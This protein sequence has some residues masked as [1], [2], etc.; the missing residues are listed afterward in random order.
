MIHR[1]QFQRTSTPV[2]GHGYDRPEGI[3][4]QSRYTLFRPSDCPN[5][6]DH[7]NPCAD[8]QQNCLPYQISVYRQPSSESLDLNVTNLSYCLGSIDDSEVGADDLK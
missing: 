4:S 3:T 5:D 7:L 6:P 8:G 2:T 1:P